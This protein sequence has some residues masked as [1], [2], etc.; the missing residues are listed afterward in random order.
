M[1]DMRKTELLEANNQIE[2]QRCIRN[3]VSDL[4]YLLFGP[5]Q[6]LGLQVLLDTLEEAE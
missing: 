1:V 4:A 3:Q 2:R 6:I 5:V